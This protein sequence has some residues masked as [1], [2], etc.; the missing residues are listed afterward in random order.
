MTVPTVVRDNDIQGDLALRDIYK[1]VSVQRAR[2]PMSRLV[3]LYISETA[4]DKSL[5]DWTEKLGHF[6]SNATNP[7]IRDLEEKLNVSGRGD[8][9]RGAILRKQQAYK[10]IMRQ[11]GS[12]SAQHIYTYILA[13]IV[14]NFEQH[15]WPLIQAQ[16]SRPLVD[17]AMADLV[18]APALESLEENPL[19]L[20]KLDIQSLVY[21]LA[22][23]CY[24]R[25]D[26][27]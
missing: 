9:V 8:L 11:Q 10:A 14:V 16:A 4:L 1:N 13:E 2:T 6:M 19:M 15:V 21:Y 12:R 27:C 22:G 24:I 3:E 23:N 20:N 25:W 18:I 7:D 17:A 26:A 5:S